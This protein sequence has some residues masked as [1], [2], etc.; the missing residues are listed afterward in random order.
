MWS[1]VCLKWV[2][3]AAWLCSLKTWVCPPERDQARTGVFGP[4]ISDFCQ[5]LSCRIVWYLRLGL[6]LPRGQP[7]WA[8]DT[9]DYSAASLWAPSQSLRTPRKQ[10]SSASGTPSFIP[11]C[12]CLT[13]HLGQPTSGAALLSPKESSGLHL[14]P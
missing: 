4:Q 3:T 10:C 13:L 11:D 14:P 2:C 7:Q 12:P 1:W 9:R 5:G 8:H 6:S